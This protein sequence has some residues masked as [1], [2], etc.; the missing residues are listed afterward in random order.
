V[1]LDPQYPAARLGL[2]LA[3][4]G[5][6]VVVTDG[7]RAGA[8][9]MGGARIVRVDDPVSGPDGAGAENLGLAVDPRNLAYV[10][11]TSGSTGEPKGVMV[12][13]RAVVRLVRDTDYVRLDRDQVLAQVSSV[14]FDAC[15]FE[16]WGA[17]LNGGRLVIGPARPPSV[18][19]LAALLRDQ[20]VTTT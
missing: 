9:E 15:T 11:F 18:E 4:A 5:A 7:A 13:H 16:V 19:E 17:L 8:F 6:P 10:I 2:M 3:S 1:P 12:P 20:G 14:S